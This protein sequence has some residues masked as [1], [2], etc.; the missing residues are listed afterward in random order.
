M[1][2]DIWLEI[3]TGAGTMAEV[4]EVGNM[5]SNVAP[6]WRKAMPDEYDGLAG[7][8]GLR[9]SDVIDALRGAVDRMKAEPDAYRT[10][11]P[12]N[13]WGDYESALEYLT[14]LCGLAMAH[15]ACFIRVSR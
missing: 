13:G 14:N 7:L 2:Y 15:P 10:M 12:P 1:S 5:T 9:C 3:D 8:D 4:A 6:M 11:N